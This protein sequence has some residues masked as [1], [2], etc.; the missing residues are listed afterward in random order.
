MKKLDCS[1]SQAIPIITFTVFARHDPK[2]SLLDLSYKV[3]Q[4]VLD[5][6]QAV[7]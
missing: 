4:N 2:I 3:L 7:G 1:L 6:L 5:H